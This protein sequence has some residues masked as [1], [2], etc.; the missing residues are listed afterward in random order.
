MVRHRR[1]LRTWAR[2]GNL[3]KEIQAFSGDKRETSHVDT[4][5]PGAAYK[6]FFEQTSEEEVSKTDDEN[7][8]SRE[9]SITEAAHQEQAAS[10]EVERK[11][12]GARQIGAEGTRTPGKRALLCTNYR[13]DSDRPI[14]KVSP[15]PCI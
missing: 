4:D 7:G 10:I 11:S 5:N 3:L 15:P 12:L 14:S 1:I 13:L 9:G 6:G 8:G 2:E